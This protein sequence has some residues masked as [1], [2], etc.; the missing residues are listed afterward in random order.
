MGGAATRPTAFLPEDWPTA[1]LVG[2]VH[3]AAGPTPVLC[4]NGRLADMSE[5]APTVAD[6][7]NAWPAEGE[8]RDLGP[9]DGFD[10]T[11]HPLLAPVDLA[12]PLRS[13]LWSG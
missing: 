9:V 11:D 13:R 6:L 10:F 5:T 7:L 8:G 2:R 1:T 3:L 12:S 4:R